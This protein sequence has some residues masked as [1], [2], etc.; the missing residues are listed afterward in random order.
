[1][2][3][4]KFI[5]KILRGFYHPSSFLLN[6]I[7]RK[8]FTNPDEVRHILITK[9]DGLG[10]YMM[11]L[12]A[13]ISIKKY[14]PTAKITQIVSSQNTQIAETISPNYIVYESP[15]FY[16]YKVGFIKSLSIIFKV[17]KISPDLIIDFRGDF[18]LL[19]GTVLS[20][21]K[22]RLEIGHARLFSTFVKLFARNGS[23]IYKRL[24]SLPETELYNKLILDSKVELLSSSD[25]R[26]YIENQ[27]GIG[28][29]EKKFSLTDEYCCIHIGG[30]VAHKRWPVEYYIELAASIF[31]K[32]QIKSVFVGSKDDLNLLNNTELN[33]SHS[34]NLI[35]KTNIIELLAVIKKAKL[36]VAN[37][38]AAGHIAAFWG[39]P[40]VT[41]FG[42]ASNEKMFRP[43]GDGVT[44]ILKSMCYC[45]TVEQNY[46]PL[47]SG[48]CMAKI[49]V[50]SVLD[51]INKLSDYDADINF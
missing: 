26:G 2:L 30:S 23:N 7:F 47:G 1:M 50:P 5:Y 3:S 43:H 25:C 31:S 49:D 16:P 15:F 29:V 20:F 51:E 37:D 34:I 46:C 10:D 33:L 42:G 24:S 27:I 41:I 12:R 48:W 6:F 14:F 44:S 19:A 38:S 21:P 40:V 8:N 9:I 28:K 45:T 4:N 32:Y 39:T 13:I 18:F 22:Y 11:A 35:S 17:Q 36:L